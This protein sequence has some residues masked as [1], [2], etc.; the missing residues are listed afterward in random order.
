[1]S[2]HNIE[3]SSNC[4]DND[5]NDVFLAQIRECFGRVA[6]SHKTHEKQVD[7]LIKKDTF[8]RWVQIILSIVASG[9]FIATFND[10]FGYEKAW[11]LIGAILSALLAAINLCFKNFN[12][13]KQAQGH[14]EI[15]SQLW[16]VRETYISLIADLMAGS[17]NIKDARETREK[18]QTK[19][20][21]IYKKAPQTASKAYTKAQK[22]LKF[23]E[24]LTFSS[25]EIDVLL[26][27]RLRLKDGKKNHDNI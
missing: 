25:D 17:I 18:L 1:M 26:P 19:L 16:D 12:Y 10:L 13:G 3:A 15:A 24:E 21:D 5:A 20:S 4:G 2:C 9:S 6:Y 23:N 22:A 27:D 14:K 7:I 8:W 11:S